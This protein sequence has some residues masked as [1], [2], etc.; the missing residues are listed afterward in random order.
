[1]R[2]YLIAIA[3]LTVILGSIAAYYYKQTMASSG[4]HFTP[5][6]VSVAAAVAKAATWSTQLDA[7]GTIIAARGVEL[8]SEAS[9]EIIAINVKSGSQ[10]NVGELLITLNDRVEQASKERQIANLELATL[11]FERDSKLVKQKSI[12][13]SQYDRSKADLDGAIAQ[14]AET[15]ARLDNKRVQAPFAGTIGIIHVKLG[16]Y[17]EP[18]D[19]ITTLQDLSELEIDFTVPERNFPMLRPGLDIVVKSSAL[20]GR[21]LHATLQA[22]DSMVESSTRN[23]LLRASLSDGKGLLPGMFAELTIDLDTPVTMVT[24]PETAVSYSLSGNIVYVID[25][26]DDGRTASP[27]V[28]TV[29]DSRDGLV[30]ILDGVEAGET[31]VSAGQ[32]K[33]FRGAT[34]T[35]D[36]S[37]N[38]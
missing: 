9:G 36:E 25:N 14:L 30:A 16:D 26:T 10:V 7:I 35:V 12:P 15:E 34:V 2:G 38:F 6:P 37:V 11:L 8:S 28:V 24:V 17:V 19:S 1:L 4:A 33:L 21:E 27:R 18:G 29:G 5:P 22:M 3:L 13:Q 31:V 20:P 23:L 32:N